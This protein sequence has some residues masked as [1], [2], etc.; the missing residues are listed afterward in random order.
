LANIQVDEDNFISNFLQNQYSTGVKIK[1]INDEDKHKMSTS[2]ERES[3]ED[4]FTTKND[5]STIKNKEICPSK[6]LK[7]STNLTA[8]QEQKLLVVLK[9]HIGSFA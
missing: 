7:I 6:T 3:W 2:Q 4:I 8:E 1:G 5:N 9:K